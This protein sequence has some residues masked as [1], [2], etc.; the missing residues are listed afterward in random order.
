MSPSTWT[1]PRAQ[2]D[3]HYKD[4]A[5]EPKLSSVTLE[6]LRPVYTRMHMHLGAKPREVSARKRVQLDFG[7]VNPKTSSANATPGDLSW[8]CT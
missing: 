7:A 8:Y 1:I 3:P 4:L 5:G 6:K 2:A